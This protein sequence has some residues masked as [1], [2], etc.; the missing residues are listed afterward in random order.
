MSQS[1]QIPNF[2]PLSIRERSTLDADA[3]IGETA[4]VLSYA[5]NFAA[6]DYLVVGRLGSES[7]ELLQV[8]A[9][10]NDVNIDLVNA[11]V[12]DHSRFD[13]VNLLYGNQI[14]IY[15]AANVDGNVPDDDS[16]DPL[17][18]AIDID[19]DQ[20][21]T[22]YTDPDGGENYWYKFTYYNSTADIETDLASSAAVRGGGHG[23]YASV[24]AIRQA[25][26]FAG[27][28]YITD[29]LIATKR[30][31][32]QSVIDSEL[33]GMYVVPFEKPINPLIVE[34]TT[35]LAAGYLL[36]DEY[37]G[38]SARMREQGQA[39]VD[40][41]LAKLTRIN[42]KELVLTGV[43]GVTQTVPDAGGYN[44][45]PNASTGNT[46]TDPHNGAPRMFTT[47]DRY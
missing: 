44:A 12:K 24:D 17:G 45:W 47:Q 39:K 28:R 33:T 23:N 21:Q 42:N 30:A 32:A 10:S 13:E 38:T 36:L 7:A 41:A 20:A 43:T 1:L 14:R 40:Q 35:E 4:L 19:I 34:I 25:A 9:V 31:A 18:S 16:F 3:A 46:P 27:N 8:Q 2:T 11:I 22:A 5:D 15:R 29:T 6:D 26:G 37:G